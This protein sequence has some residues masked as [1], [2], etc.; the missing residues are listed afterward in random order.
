VKRSFSILFIIGAFA[1]ALVQLAPILRQSA[2]NRFGPP[3]QWQQNPNERR[4]AGGPPEGPPFGGGRQ[5]GGGPPFAGGPPF[6][7]GPRF[8]RRGPNF[9]N[10]PAGGIQEPLKLV[11]QF[12]KNGDGWLDADERKTAREFLEKERAEGRGR[13]GLALR[14]RAEGQPAPDSGPKVSPTEVKNFPEAVLYDLPALRTIFIDFADADWEQELSDFYQTDVEVPANLTVD[15]KSYPNVGVEFRSAASLLTP[16]SGR[17]YSIHL[18]TD[19]IDKDQNLYGYRS[20]NLLDSREAPNFLRSVLYLQAAREYIAAPKANFVRVVI[21]GESRGISV[22]AQQFNKDFT[23]EW[24]GSA[25]GTRW[26]VPANP[27]AKGGLEYLGEHAGPYKQIY[28]IKSKDD[29]KSWRTLITLCRVLSETPPEQLEQELSPL[30]D[31]DG[32][33]K[34]LALENA[35]INSDGYWM[36]ASDYSIYLDP[37]DHFHIVPRDAREAFHEPGGPGGRIERGVELDPLRGAEDPSRPLL[38]KLLAVPSLRAKYL[39]Y[40]REIAEKWLDWKKL[41]PLVDQY[42]SIVGADA[43]SETLK[44][45]STEALG[46]G[47]SMQTARPG[48]GLPPKV[49]SLR[50][51]VEQRQAF[52]LNHPAIKETAVKEASA[53]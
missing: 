39:G 31:I 46:T 34:F 33:L 47:V 17:R 53:K 22:N 28:E 20:L 27:R 37:E 49:M 51:F 21:N 4:F 35:L 13:R 43:K 6:G 41:E 50:D 12:D 9:G 38:N 40:V 3:P 25:K 19:F 1:F 32:T 15:G 30:L 52:L 8:F 36:L 10:G 42:Q 18:A 29:K 23:K 16:N 45:Y 26:N 7:G 14:G 24:F 2:E 48:F 5:F 11:S 44:L